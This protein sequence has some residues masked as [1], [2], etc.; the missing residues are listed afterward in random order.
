MVVPSPSM[1]LTSKTVASSVDK[2]MSRYSHSSACADKLE[3]RAT[4]LSH[5]LLRKLDNQHQHILQIVASQRRLGIRTRKTAYRYTLTS[6]SRGRNQRDDST[7]ILVLV[8]RQRIQ[9]LL[10]E[11]ENGSIQSLL[12][13]S[14]NRF[15]LRCERGFESTVG[16]R[17][18]AVETIDLVERYD[19]GS[20]SVSKQS[21]RFERLRLESVLIHSVR[22]Q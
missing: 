15:L 16:N 19:E 9:S 2:Y 1:T 22:Y 4:Y 13:L 6:V 12:V 17:F 8:V 18:P 14:S 10:S 5:L 3:A 21:E 7:E 11:S 20:L